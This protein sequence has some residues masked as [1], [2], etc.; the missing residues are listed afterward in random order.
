MDI[1]LITAGLAAGIWLLIILHRQNVRKH[2]PWFVAYVVWQV[3]Q[4]LVQ[5]LAVLVISRLYITLYWWME[6]VDMLLTVAAVRESFLRIFKGFTKMPWFRWTVSGVIA[7]IVAYSAWKAIYHP[8]VQ[9]TWLTSF[10]VGIEFLFRWGIAGIAALTFVLSWAL[11]EPTETWEDT[12]LTG[13]GLISGAFI[14][15]LICVSLFGN[16]FLSFS[17]Y[18]PSVGYFI[19]I[20]LWIRVFSRPVESFGFKELGIGPEDLLK[21]IRRYRADVRKIRGKQ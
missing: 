18:A 2:L 14:F 16:K 19:A 5:L 1:A 17:K 4:A 6:A 20:F 9:G 10:V 12:I 8:P 13:F 11:S 21:L 15:S 7:A 3:L